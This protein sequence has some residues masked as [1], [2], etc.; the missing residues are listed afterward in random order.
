MTLDSSER[1]QDVISVVKTTYQR[2]V[3]VAEQVLRQND[4]VQLFGA[5]DHKHGYRVN[6]VV[7]ERELG[8][9]RLKGLRHDLAP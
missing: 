3:H 9:L 2:Y 7:V 5:R 8:L 1:L 6:E 4:T